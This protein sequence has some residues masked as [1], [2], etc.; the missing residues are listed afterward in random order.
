MQERRAWRPTGPHHIELGP[1]P[2]GLERRPSRFLHPRRR[3]DWGLVVLWLLFGFLAVAGTA[4]LWQATRVD[5]DMAG[6]EDDMAMTPGEAVGLQATLTFAKSNHLH[7]AHL[8]FDGIDVL[9]GDDPELAG[10]VDERGKTLVWTAPSELAE[11]EHRLKLSVPRLAFGDASFAWDV[12]VDGTPPV[13]DVAATLDPVP[14]DEPVTVEGR[15]EKG[16][17]LTVDGEETETDGGQFELDFDRPP[18]GPITLVAIDR[19]GNAATTSVMVPVQMASVHGVHVTAV[20]WGRE[21]YRQHIVGLIDAGLI[22]TVELDLKDE[23]GVVGYDSEVERAKAIGA[24]RPEYDLAE[25][26][27]FLEG[28][29]VRVVGR[30]VAFRDPILAAVA[31]A[32]GARDQVIQDAAG[33]PFAGYGG[34]TN[35]ANPDVRRY[36]LD[37]AVE[38][39]E[40]GVDN[41]L[42]DYVRRPEG[43]PTSMVVPGLGDRASTDVVADFMAESHAELRSR[44]A[45]QGASVF[46][47]AAK[48]PGSIGQSIP[49]LARHVDY[50]APMVYP[51]HFGEGQ[52]GVESPIDQP[53][54]IVAASLADFQVQAENSG[55]RFVPWLQD[56]TIYGTAYGPDQ[57]R[58]QIDAARSLGIDGFLLWNPG[59]V[60]TADALTPLGG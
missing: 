55:A 60:Y 22:D 32:E 25:A 31:W 24:V 45:I 35:Y 10:T 27:R 21:E 12:V 6:V 47:I 28:K 1:R 13:F 5:V 37:I 41:I 9:D 54:E 8:T 46:G 52:Y 19:A 40:A 33:Q 14:I 51:S 7:A 29:G 42:W 4:L 34:F 16:A 18:T 2:L 43:A 26:V 11:G 59:V 56:F 58:A 30:I 15:V 20:A 36:N 57:V 38:A 48:S 23:H 39:V 44:G 53:A 17:T 3:L 50:I 49:L